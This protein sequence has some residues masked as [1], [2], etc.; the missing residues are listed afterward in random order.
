MLLIGNQRECRIVCRTGLT[1]Q[2]RTLDETLDQ[3]RN[4]EGGCTTAPIE[5]SRRRIG[6]QLHGL[7]WTQS[8]DHAVRLRPQ[9]VLDHT[10]AGALYDPKDPFNEAVAA[11]YVQA[12][13]RT[14]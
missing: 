1:H 2:P 6:E 10:T 4:R 5:A 14:R 13:R 9:C 8:G 3:A 7:R 11:F 12:L